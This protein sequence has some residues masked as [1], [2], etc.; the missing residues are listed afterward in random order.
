MADH[1]LYPSN[2]HLKCPYPVLNQRYLLLLSVT[3]LL[4]GLVDDYRNS[5]W[6]A[7]SPI[8]MQYHEHHLQIRYPYY[9]SGASYGYPDASVL[10]CL[11]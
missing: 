7:W 1:T 10:H 2:F 3:S 8:Q 9:P 5:I 6:V 11:L 4:H